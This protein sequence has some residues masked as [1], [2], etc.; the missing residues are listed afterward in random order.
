MGVKVKT[1]TKKNII[2]KLTK[3]IEALNGKK[4]QVGVLSGEHQWLAAIHE[5]GADITPKNAQYLTV[6]ISPKAKGKSAADFPDLFFVQAKSGEKFLAQDKAKGEIELLFWLT[7]SVHI[8]ERSFLR[9][10]Y[11]TYIDSVMKYS[12]DLLKMVADGTMSAEQYLDRLGQ[13]LST[14]IKKYARDLSSPANSAA[15]EEV[16][17]SNNPLVDTGAM[18]E[19]ITWRTK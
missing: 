1:K 7:K 6:P 9:S 15:T 3:E 2:P 8:P 14:K 4:V 5:Y 17:G 10:G 18:I 12:D 11:D 19:G 16:K 13:E